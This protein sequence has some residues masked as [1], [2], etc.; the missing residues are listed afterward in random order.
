MGY[1]GTHV[2][3]T[4]DAPS[5]N[6]S[7]ASSNDYETIQSSPDAFGAGVAKA[8]EGLGNSVVGAADTV[9][10]VMVQRQTEANETHA[11]QL[12]TW[13][14]DKI[15]DHLSQYSRLQGQDSLNAL[16][17]FKQG[18]DD[19]N[20][21]ALAQAGDSPQMQR[22]VATR[23]AALV[24]QYY[25]LGT[26]HADQQ[27]LS[28]Q[29][30]TAIDHAQA[31]ANHASVAATNGDMTMSENA[32][33]M[34]DQA[35]R[36]N[37]KKQGLDDISVDQE[38]AKNR[39]RSVASITE[40]LGTVGIA[41]TGAPNLDLAQAFFKKH[42]EEMDAPTRL[43]VDKWLAPRMLNRQA[44]S[45]VSS[46]LSPNAE[47]RPGAGADPGPGHGRGSI[48]AAYTAPLNVAPHAGGPAPQD[49]YDYALSKGATRNEAILLTSASASEGVFNPGALH[50]RDANG[51]PTGYG[52]FGHRLD[53]R[54][55]LFRDAGTNTPTWQQQT[56]FALKELRGRPEASLVNTATTP[57]ELANAE[58]HYEQPRAYTSSDPQAGENYNGRLN[59]IRRF[60]AQLGGNPDADDS[61]NPVKPGLDKS[62]V[63]Q[64]LTDLTAGNPAL[65]AKVIS[66]AN[67]RYAQ[68][69]AANATETQAIKLDFPNQLAAAEA[70][71]ANAQIPRDRISAL[72]P[73]PK[74]QSMLDQFDIAQ[75]VGT[76]MTGI[77]FASPDEVRAA[78]QDIESGTG[79]LSTIMKSHSKM[80]ATGPGT[81][82]ADQADD[83]DGGYFRLRVSAAARL[84]K[85]IDQRGKMLTGPNADPAAYAVA[86][87]SVKAAADAAQK[88][89]SKVGDYVN[90]TLG[91]QEHLGVPEDQQ[92]VFTRGQAIDMAQ[93]VMSSGTDVRQNLQSLQQHF[94]D[95]Y[96]KVFSDLVQLGKLPSSYQAVAALPD[97]D[98][99]AL[100]ARAL[101]EAPGTGE[102]GKKVESWNQR[103][104]V[105]T[106]SVTAPQ[107]L[108]N[109]VLSH[110]ELR[111]YLQTLNRQGISGAPL[112]N[113]TND[114]QTLAQAH[115]YYKQATPVDAATKAIE[116]FTKQ[117]TILPGG[118]ARIPSTISDAVMRDA[119]A[120]VA[121]LSK[122]SIRIPPA[123][124]GLGQPKSEDLISNIQ[125]NHSWRNTPKGDG[126]VLMDGSGAT[127]VDKAGKPLT[128]PF[129]NAGRAVVAPPKPPQFAGP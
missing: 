47:Y 35:I 127:V 25:K 50:D 21:Q 87:P 58:M 110:P 15:T 126:L 128:V 106:G 8:E 104:A 108:K 115:V 118:Q 69:G 22:M 114:I 129:A 85:V 54:D 9:N 40:Q 95:A 2:L 103:L 11:A 89:P 17:A 52:M 90:A 80:G 102:D 101:H 49:M 78:A 75:K 83:M 105:A 125:S 122:D 16:P 31:F 123:V 24:D 51:N 121:G 84:Q 98:D 19:L 42:E 5:V 48:N 73:G 10:S 109:A 57:V 116:A 91:M 12:Q 64:K 72:F 55:A 23:G 33:I 88:D 81:M 28:W 77:Q 65:Q 100:L 37:A 4:G 1:G 124:G 45:L 7:G 62:A 113:I 36:E 79:H 34:S 20:K 86:E 29:N 119:D 67:R 92:H 112:D 71:D 94:G 32:L 76:V 107:D 56:D 96:P 6:P 38:V 44:E 61:A 39:G 120:M 70:G 14:S 82:G 74:A 30:K 53:R 43:A 59:T 46:V 93:H 60:S 26:Q 97:A 27:F 68:F 99:A 3:E 111:D 117:F 13:L 18:L 41:G 66:V 63:L